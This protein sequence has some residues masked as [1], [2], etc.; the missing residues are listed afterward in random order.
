MCQVLDTL[1]CAWYARPHAQEDHARARLLRQ[2]QAVVATAGVESK[3]VS[4]PRLRHEALA[5]R[6]RA[7]VEN[8]KKGN[9][10]SMNINAKSMSATWR[11]CAQHG[12]EQPNV[13]G[14]APCLRELRD[15]NAQLRTRLQEAEQH[16]MRHRRFHAVG[17]CPGGGECYVCRE[18]AL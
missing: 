9:G 7:D 10:D 3:A 15:E 11:T 18:E 17:G 12:D 6:V 1:S 13:Y 16:M 4:L 2:V 5:Q 8:E 14:C